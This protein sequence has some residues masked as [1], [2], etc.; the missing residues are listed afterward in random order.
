VILVRE[1]EQQM[2]SSGCC[3]RIEG[4]VLGHGEQRVFAERREIMERM[5][6]VY[7]AV[8][9]RFGDAVE[10][11][12]V[13][14]RNQIVLVPRLV[15]DAIRYRVGWRQVLGTLRGLST[16]TVIVNGRLFARG[17]W[18]EPRFLV[19]HLERLM[20]AEEGTDRA[21]R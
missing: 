9:T 20:R 17:A 1:W 11:L 6:P 19:T 10:L 18:P 16:V 4:D 2:S 7:R 21:S 3:G 8:R 12:V 15:R 5:G 13:D 14:P